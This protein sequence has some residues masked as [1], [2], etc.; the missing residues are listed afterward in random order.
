[1]TRP[2]PDRAASATHRGLEQPF[3][4]GDPRQA[5]KARLSGSSSA[6]RRLSP[7]KRSQSSTIHRVADRKDEKALLDDLLAGLDAS[8]FELV[9]S[10]PAVSQKL[11]THNRSS[12]LSPL[13][14][15]SNEAVLDMASSGVKDQPV[16]RAKKEALSPNK[17]RLLSIE[18]K[19]PGVLQQNRVPVPV[20]L[21]QIDI[22]PPPAIDINI[23]EEKQAGLKDE[24]EDFD[25]ELFAFDLE[26]V[27]FDALDSDVSVKL[28]PKASLA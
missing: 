17:R 23:K 21:E 8:M 18:L 3:P 24:V 1:M 7:T 6:K 19:S 16:R 11:G 2:S 14:S 27:D 10:S 15:R 4:S 9:P 20:K 26:D 5:K 12:Q 13:K 22:P 25:D 28:D